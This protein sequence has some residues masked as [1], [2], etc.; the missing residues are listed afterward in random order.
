MDI[1][2]S[3]FLFSRNEKKSTSEEEEAAKETFLSPHSTTF[4]YVYIRH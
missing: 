2:Y 4:H 1:G 3:N